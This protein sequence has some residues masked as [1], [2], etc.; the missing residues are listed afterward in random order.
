M[1]RNGDVGVG[2]IA[3]KDR[4]LGKTLASVRLPHTRKEAPVAPP[5]ALRNV[6][7]SGGADDARLCLCRGRRITPVG[8]EGGCGGIVGTNCG[9][10]DDKRTEALTISRAAP[11]VGGVVAGAMSVS[12]LEIGGDSIGP[13][14]FISPTPSL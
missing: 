1:S 9:G 3:S 14:P 6:A 7:M 8:G 11:L 10:I 4:F 5:L 2:H 13:K 12:V